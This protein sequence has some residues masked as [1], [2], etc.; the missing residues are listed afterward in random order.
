MHPDTFS[1]FED[2][3]GDLSP[4]TGT[5]TQTIARLFGGNAAAWAAF[6]P[7]T[8]MKKHG[9]YAGIAGWFAVNGGPQPQ[10]RVLEAGSSAI[11]LGRDGSGR[12]GD[13][14]SAA[15]SLCS[16]GSSNG[17]DCAVVTQPGKHDWPFAANAFATAL[18]W[19]AGQLGTPGVAHVS[20]SAAAAAMPAPP[21]APPHAPTQRA[22][23][24]G[25]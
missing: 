11:D 7:T 3:A 17:I 20:L 24:A 21:Q 5:R 12:P 25:R 1:A 10:H 19:L 16:L 4:N 13:Q 6:D 18:P 2:I 14:L 9:R 8:V 15:N 22:Q 23:A